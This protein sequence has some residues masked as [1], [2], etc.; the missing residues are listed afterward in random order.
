[1]VEITNFCYLLWTYKGQQLKF[2]K[3]FKYLPSTTSILICSDGSCTKIIDSINNTITN[4]EPSVSDKSNDYNS[5][6]S[7]RKYK[8]QKTYREKW[9]VNKKKRRS[10]FAYS[11][12]QL[13]MFEQYQLKTIVPLGKLFINS[14]IILYRKT[15]KITC[16]SSQWLEKQFHS[17]GYVW[18]RE[19]I[20]L[21]K[22]NPFIILEELFSPF[23]TRL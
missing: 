7:W 15:C 10:L 16:L 20:F 2:N 8:I 11:V 5:T 22:E 13:G 17:K 6:Y 12:Y 3:L 4:T 9:L 21:H 14:E 19:Y 18:S 1:M 23:L